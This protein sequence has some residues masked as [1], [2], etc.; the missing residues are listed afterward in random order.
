MDTIVLEEFERARPLPALDFGSG[1]AG[2]GFPLGTDALFLAR[3]TAL[4]A[5]ERVLDL[6]T[7]RGVI[8][9]MLAARED[10]RVVGLDRDGEALREAGAN[11][12]RNGRLLKGKTLWIRAD[13]RRAPW[14]AGLPGFDLIIM[15]PPFFRKGEGRL[16]PDPYRAAAR[17]ELDGGLADWVGAAADALKPN[18]RLVCAHRPERGEELLA[19]LGD[20]GFEISEAKTCR[21]AHSTRPKWL[22]VQAL[23]ARP[24]Q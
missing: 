21:P 23:L 15:N 14:K 7:G 18:G 2:A 13:L 22:L 16:P 4:R 24:R 11:E 3:A 10:I 20:K 1:H 17:H 19:L 5:G 9:L 12:E 6:G 8:A